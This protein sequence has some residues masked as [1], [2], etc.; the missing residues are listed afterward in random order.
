MLTLKPN[1]EYHE[2]HHPNTAAGMLLHAGTSTSSVE[3]RYGTGETITA[4][5]SCA[6]HN[7]SQSR[8]RRTDAVG[9]EKVLKSRVLPLAEDFGALRHTGPGTIHVDR[10]V[11]V[12]GKGSV[13]LDT[14]AS[15]GKKNPTNRNYATPEIIRPLDREDLREY[16]RFS[17]WVYVDAPGVYLT[18][19][20]F[21]L[22]NEG[23]KSCRLPDALKDNTSRL[24]IPT[25]GNTSYGR[26]RTYTVIVSPAFR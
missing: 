20:G 19:A 25:N 17:V 3:T 10:K 24:S 6:P 16:N 4:K 2:T 23:E 13:R 21:T 15:L 18:F 22:Y 9:K 12:S 5:Q 1:T 11:T 8:T 7:E 26:Y 14:P